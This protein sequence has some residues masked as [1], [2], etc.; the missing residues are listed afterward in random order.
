MAKKLKIWIITVDGEV[1]A[2]YTSQKKA[3]DEVERLID[4]E[5]VARNDI[6][7]AI[8]YPV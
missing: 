1:W 6:Y 3:A 7:T 4:D 8:R 2:A 5:G